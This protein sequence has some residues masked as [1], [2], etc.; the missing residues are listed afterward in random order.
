MRASDSIVVESFSG[1]TVSEQKL[2]IVERKGLGH[3]DSICDAVMEFASIRLAAE[4]QRQFGTVLHYNLDKSLLC[5]GAAECQFGGGIIKSPMRFIMGDRATW[6]ADG[7]EIPVGEIAI[8]AA[9]E[10]F[11]NH[12][13]FLDPEQHVEYQLEIKPGSSELQDIFRSKKTMRAAND[14]SAGVGYAPLTG[15]EKAVL[16]TEKYLNSKIFKDEFPETGEDVKIMGIRKGSDLHLTIAMPLVDRFIENE[17]S[18]FKRKTDVW[19]AIKTFLDEKFRNFEKIDVILNS[20]DKKGKG[21]NGI[22]L[23][24]LGT[25]AEVA[26]SG[27]VGRGN[28]VN[29]LIS[30]GRPC[31]LEA[32]AGKNAISHV[33]KIYNVFANKVAIQIYETLSGIQEVYVTLVSR[34]GSPI[35]KPDA[36]SIKLN[37]KK[38]VAVRK[39]T[40]HAQQIVEHELSGLDIFCEDL[41]QGKYNIY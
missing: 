9:K 26:D 34:I 14:T 22:Y 40:K 8:A 4:Y 10:W 15:T 33:G 41:I 32:A 36:V 39:I 27:E 17:K 30:F 16:E 18:Y 21:I 1:K 20:L 29:G 38:N 2:E 11:R 24:V 5:A 12:F 37:L 3:P 19:K 31:S 13:R 28:R 23:S 6:K 7:K 25:S 35:D